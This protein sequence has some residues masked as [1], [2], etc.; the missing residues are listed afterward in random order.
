ML[1]EVMMEARWTSW[2]PLDKS[3]RGHTRAHTEEASAVGSRSHMKGL[4]GP[5]GREKLLAKVRRQNQK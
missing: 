5:T 4:D 1:V 2:F 3:Q